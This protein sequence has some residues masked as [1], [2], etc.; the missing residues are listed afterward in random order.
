MGILKVLDHVLRLHG[1]RQGMSM[2][3][4]AMGWISYILSKADH[5]MSQVESWAAE[6]MEAVRARLPGL[7][8]EKDFIDARLSTHVKVVFCAKQRVGWRPFEIIV[9]HLSLRSTDVLQAS[10]IDKGQLV[11]NAQGRRA[12]LQRTKSFYAILTYPLLDL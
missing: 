7:S 3:W 11:E 2:G 5:R 12:R 6:R 10:A 4:L 8:G 9:L 1:N